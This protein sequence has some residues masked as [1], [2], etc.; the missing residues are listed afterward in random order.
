MAIRTPTPPDVLLSWHRA[1][2]R[3]PITPRNEEE[4]QIGWYRLRMTKGGPWVPVRIWLSQV[5]DE[6]GELMEP[7]TLHADVGGEAKNPLNVW[8]YCQPISRD[9]YEALVASCRNIEAMAATNAPIDLT[10]LAL[11]PTRRSV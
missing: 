10:R 2:L 4:P 6:F 11:G 3:D 7:E 1:A 8:T 5:T 9:T